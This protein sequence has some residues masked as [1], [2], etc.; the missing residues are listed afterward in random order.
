MISINNLYFRKKGVKTCFPDR[1]TKKIQQCK[2]SITAVKPH[3]GWTFL[4]VSQIECKKCK[5]HKCGLIK[6]TARRHSICRLP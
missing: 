4:V 1:D 3:D 5:I 6:K 2:K